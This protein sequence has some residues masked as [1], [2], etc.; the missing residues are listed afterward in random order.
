MSQKT[1][2]IQI[3]HFLGENLHMPLLYIE[4]GAK[5]MIPSLT[6]AVVWDNIKGII[7]DKLKEYSDDS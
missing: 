4:H 1:C 5:A 6:Q 2:F 3:N 7:A